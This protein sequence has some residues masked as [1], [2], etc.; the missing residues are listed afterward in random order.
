MKHLITFSLLLFLV[1]SCSK[2][3]IDE[4]QQN[5]DKNQKFPEVGTISNSQ[6]SP[7]ELLTINGT[8]TSDT[9]NY[10]VKFN[11]TEAEIIEKTDTYLKVKVP[12]N[13]TSGDI[14]LSYNG[15]TKVIGNIQVTVKTSE[16][17]AYKRDYSDTN[18]YIKQLVKINQTSGNEEILVSLNIEEPYYYEDLVF[19]ASSNEIIGLVKNSLLKVNIDTKTTSSVKLEKT[20]K[21]GIDY[22]DLVLDNNNNLYAY[23]RNYSDPE[24]YIKQIVKINIDSGAEE[25]IAN[26]NIASTYYK[27]LV[28]NSS[29][30][31]IIGLVENSLVKINIQEKTTS[32]VKLQKTPRE[33]IDYSNLVLDNNNNLYAYKRNYSDPKNYIKQIVKIDT[34]SGE[35]EIIT[36]LNIESTYYENLVYN[37]SSKEIIGLVQKSLLKVNIDDKTTSSVNLTTESNVDYDGLVIIK[38]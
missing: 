16:L 5:N 23:K 18:N 29:S 31:E 25:I 20:P 26:L 32:S 8:F 17:Y 24:N 7:G 33:G 2:D 30:K 28:Y 10:S 19:K 13:A 6:L 34:I 12:E 15:T 37:P 4:N 1:T 11:G 9:N 35:E 3:S 21:E 22:S 14:T 38:R 36:N 27:S